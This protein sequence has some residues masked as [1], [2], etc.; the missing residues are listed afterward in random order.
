MKMMKFIANIV[1][2]SVLLGCSSRHT[3]INSKNKSDLSKKTQEKTEAELDKESSVYPPIK[4]FP[5][6]I[7]IVPI[8]YID[9][10]QTELTRD[11]DYNP[12]TSVGGAYNILVTNKINHDIQVLGP[13]ITDYPRIANKILAIEDV[14]G[15]GYLDILAAHLPPMT[16]V[17]VSSIIYVYKPEFKNFS[18][19]EGIIQRGIIDTPLRGCIS[20]QYPFSTRPDMEIMTDF[21]CWKNGE[22][23]LV[24]LKLKQPT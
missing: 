2:L 10:E 21:Y 14:N 5:F 16:S 15:D 11:K 24:N 3:P 22:W 20:V 7:K 4:D 18:E 8:L 9:E 6:E 17:Y 19:S 12:K 1:L 13:V 23:K